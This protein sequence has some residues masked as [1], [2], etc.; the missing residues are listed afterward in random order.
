LPP[1]NKKGNH[2]YNSRVTS[3]VDD[4]MLMT[5]SAPFYLNYF[6]KYVRL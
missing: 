2:Y 6:H 1:R 5:I 3:T 4:S